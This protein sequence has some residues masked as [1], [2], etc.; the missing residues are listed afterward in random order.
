MALLTSHTGVIKEIASADASTLRSDMIKYVHNSNALSL[1]RVTNG[2]GGLAA[3]T[4]SNRQASNAY[5]RSSSQGPVP[6]GSYTGSP[7]YTV[8]NT[9]QHITQTRLSTGLPTDT[10]NRLYPL[11]YDAVLGGIRSSTADEVCAE[12]IDPIL[13]EMVLGGDHTDDTVQY[14]IATSTPSGFSS[15][16]SVYTDRIA[17]VSSFNGSSTNTATYSFAAPPSATVNWEAT[18][19]ILSSTI[20]T[21]N[22]YK[23]NASANTNSLGLMYLDVLGNIKEYTTTELATVLTPLISWRMNN[24]GSPKYM[25][26][27][28]SSVIYGSIL[29]TGMINRY[30]SVSWNTGTNPWSPTTYWYWGQYWPSGSLTT[31][32]TYYLQI[33]WA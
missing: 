5:F 32:S 8:I 10:A 11:R 27:L 2:T 26:Y 3:M 6:V 18:N 17:S 4:N 24:S 21:Y 19:S 25:Q 14:T 7:S 33:G 15:L 28:N 20:L 9:F 1:T 23:R 31:V 12:M 13:D 16:G 22:L 30:Y 29:G